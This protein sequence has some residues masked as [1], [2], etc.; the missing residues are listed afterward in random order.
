M[1]TLIAIAAPAAARE[2]TAA[3]H[4]MVQYADLDLNHASGADA[5]ISRLQQAAANACRNFS[6]RDLGQA[7][8][9]KA[10][11]TETMAAAVKQV[12]APLVSARYG[13]PATSSQF[14]VK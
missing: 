10:C 13:S 7:A 5:L 6:T 14:A 3:P 8:E 2:L 1:K 4:V 9:K 12:N 11:M